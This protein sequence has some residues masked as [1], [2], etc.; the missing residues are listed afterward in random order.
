M[1][2]RFKETYDRASMLKDISDREQ[3]INNFRRTE[4]LYQR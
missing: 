4:Y 1:D 3:M 2:N